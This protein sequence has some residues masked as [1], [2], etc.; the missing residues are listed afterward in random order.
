MCIGSNGAGCITSSSLSSS[1]SSSSLWL[2]SSSGSTYSS[3]S[4]DDGLAAD[5]ENPFNILLEACNNDP[6]LIR[7]AYTKHRTARNALSRND[8]LS[9]DF[10][11]PTIDPFLTALVAHSPSPCELVETDALDPRNCLTVWARPSEAIK[12]LVEEV[13]R[14]LIAGQLTGA[15]V[16]GKQFWTMPRR[17]LHLTALEVIHSTTAAAVNDLVERIGMRGFREIVEWPKGKGVRLGQPFLS[18]DKAAL[19]IS[20]LP[21]EGGDDKTYTY[22]HLRRDL[23]EQIKKRGVDI[24]SRYVVPSAHITVGRFIQVAPEVEAAMPNVQKEMARWIQVIDEVNQ[25]LEKEGKDY[26]R[27]ESGK[28]T[29]IWEINNLDC[30]RG[31]VWY[32]GGVTVVKTAE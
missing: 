19:A 3:A 22:H 8:I 25:W 14:R 27:G 9:K 4:S 5:S 32:G 28:G 18:F 26:I 2:S 24:E 21:M 13:Q 16:P 20:F 7:S 15:N 6:E 23:W 17:C 30:R 31:R 1:S 10:P 12:D 29:P 11:G